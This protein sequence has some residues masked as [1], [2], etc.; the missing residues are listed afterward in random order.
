MTRTRLSVSLALFTTLALGVA[1]NKKA[2]MEPGG[3]DE[4]SSPS[5]SATG[6]ETD[7]AAKAEAQKRLRA[8]GLA[9]QNYEL[10][11]GGQPLGIVTQNG[12][13]G[14]SWRVAILP[15][16]DGDDAASLYHRLNLKEPWDSEHNKKLI[17]KMPKVYES[18]GKKPPEGKT[19][20]RSFVGESAFMR[21]PS[22]NVYVPEGKKR[23]GPFANYVP[24]TPARGRTLAT[25]SDGSS[26]TIAV[27]EAADPVEWTKPEELPYPGFPGAP[28]PPP[29]PKLGGPFA[30]GFHVL[31]GDG[32]AHFLPETLPEKALRAM[33]TA[34]GGEVLGPEASEILFPPK[35]K[36][37]G[38]P[39]S[40]PA[41]L[42]D[43]AAR[44][45]AVE[46]YRKLVSALHE[47]GDAMGQLPAGIGAKNGLG[48]SWRV[49]ILPMLGQKA[50]Y[51]E[52]KLAEPWDSDN[53]KRLI[54]RLPKVF[55]SPGKAAAKG[56]T[57][58]R[59]T[60][61]QGG[62]I[63]TGPNGKVQVRPDLAGGPAYGLR[64]PSGIPDGTW[65]TIL[66]V[67]AADAVPWT[68]PEELAFTMPAPV[69][70]K[71]GMTGPPKDA[72]IP[73]LGGAFADGFHA[74]V[75]DGRVTFY[76]ADYPSGEL[77]KLLCPSDGWVVD[78]LSPA[79]RIAYTI[80]LEPVPATTPQGKSAVPYVKPPK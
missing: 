52:F 24:G 12:H 67:E 80:P 13:L 71:G 36:K 21:L 60:Q 64:F 79:D 11:M 3:G 63:P 49:Q 27:A 47:H 5:P 30:G 54:E 40:V 72:K 4:R 7:S 28:K 35:P 16:L 57:F 22:G 23:P 75:A 8:I 31:M 20:L 62:I 45:L 69:V 38:P 59:M 65:N 19:Y 33:I 44:R 50:L 41:E 77:A 10:A 42:P 70:G 26:N 18:P 25:I 14:L 76:K 29:V 51:S 32:A 9:M 78:P 2:S 39:T 68:K 58:I 48:L 61:G 53:N 55:A 43:A 15:Y 66:F 17:A 56:H 1:C 6:G 73:P 74:A 37:P 46:N 34:D